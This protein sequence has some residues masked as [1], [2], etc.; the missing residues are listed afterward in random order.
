MG[1]IVSFGY[2]TSLRADFSVNQKQ[3]LKEFEISQY[4]Y[5]TENIQ[6]TTTCLERQDSTNCIVQSIEN[7]VYYCMRCFTVTRW[8]IPD[9]AP[10]FAR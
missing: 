9:I 7:K 1:I 3:K 4:I 6:A 5:V 10:S 2:F 8:W